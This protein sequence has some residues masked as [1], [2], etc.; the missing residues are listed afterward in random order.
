MKQKLSDMLEALKKSGATLA[1]K[2]RTLWSGA[3]K[4]ETLY[5]LVPVL[6][7]LV[8]LVVFVAKPAN[9]E[10]DMD[11]NDATAVEEEVERTVA[12]EGT[13]TSGMLPAASSPG[14]EFTLVLS[15]DG[16]TTFTGDYKKG[17]RLVVEKGTWS[18]TDDRVT[19]TLVSRFGF[20]LEQ[21]VTHVFRVSDKSL[22][23]VDY[24]NSRW[25]SLGLTLKRS[26]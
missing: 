24:D 4:K 1:G 7:L 23:L 13:Y 26:E 25:G 6:V 21:P 3:K 2:I 11:S 5:W 9:D 12:L 18:R 16:S 8:A 20:P 17:D 22:V 14:R 19:L 10:A 15:E